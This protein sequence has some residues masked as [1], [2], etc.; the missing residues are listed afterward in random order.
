VPRNLLRVFFHDRCF[1][2]AT[3]AALFGHYF[4]STQDADTEID[5]WGMMHSDGDPFAGV[6]W[7]AD[8]NA[9][10]DFRYCAD[11][12][13][14]WWFDHHQSAF[15]PQSLRASFDEAK[16]ETHF[17]DPKARS[18]ALFTY[19]VLQ[20]ELGF[21]LADP[22]GHW[23][24]LL[25]WA[26]RIDGAVFDSAR[27]IVELGDPAFHLMI[28]LRSN[29]DAEKMS[30]T[31]EVLGRKSIADVIALPWIASEVPSLLQ[32]HTESVELIRQRLKRFGPVVAYDLAEDDVDAH[33]GF[34]AYM[35]EPSAIYSVGLV[36]SEKGAGISVGCNPWAPEIGP[37][38]IAGICEQ[39]G[40]GGHPN[41]GGIAVP[42][43][44]LKRAREIVAEIVEVLRT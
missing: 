22:H 20:Q 21:E 16:S 11:A 36:H 30:K 33:S 8:V 29:R 42:A 24:E 14:H 9:C 27:E 10:V 34:A 5:Y 7:D 25:N 18:C 3:T 13:M 32:A 12:R 44:E 19:R 17:Y 2:G 40:G 1:D 39:Y 43:G 35:F 26:D 31:I 23:N 15:Q 4:R 41:V 38:N 6:P 28:W 37:K